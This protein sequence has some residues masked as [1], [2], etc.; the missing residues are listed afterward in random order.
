[1]LEN[2]NTMEEMLR[3][4]CPLTQDEIINLITSEIGGEVDNANNILI[5]NV[6]HDAPLFIS[7]M[8]TVHPDR[9][10]S[11]LINTNGVLTAI[12]SKGQQCGIG[13]DDRCGIA[14]MLLMIKN[15]IDNVNYLFTTD[16]EI[17][18][19][20]ARNCRFP[21]HP[22]ACIELDRKSGDNLVVEAYG[23]DYA[24]SIN[25]EAMRVFTQY[26]YK[27]DHTGVL[28]DLDNLSF[29]TG[30]VNLSVGYYNP[31]RRN[32]YIVLKET[33]NCLNMCIAL[34]G[35]PIE[36]SNVRERYIDETG[37]Y[38][39]CGAEIEHPNNMNLCDECILYASEDDLADFEFDTYEI[40]YDFR[41]KYY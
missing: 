28:T 40:A 19:I 23:G 36:M 3:L 1:M 17:G 41:E 30:G 12:D 25:D 26:G 27:E 38:C 15:G 34:S 35:V 37:Y 24:T 9:E 18:C 13:G 21:L 20:G 31:H 14:I 4:L 11:D 8:D 16:E 33:E 10:I 2:I 29:M 32:E 5:M 22:S 6:E 39:E 7:H